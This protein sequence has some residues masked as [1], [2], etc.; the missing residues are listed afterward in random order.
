M[1]RWFLRIGAALLLFAFIFFGENLLLNRMMHARE[2]SSEEGWV[3]V[4]LTE[5]KGNPSEVIDDQFLCLVAGV[6][7]NSGEEN[8]GA[9]TRSDTLMLVKADFK[10][11]KLQL[12]SLPRDTRVSVNGEKTKLNH[13]HSYGGIELTMQ[14]V[15]NWLGIDLDY[16]VEVS[17][18]AVKHIVDTLGGVEYEIPDDGIQYDIAYT[19][20][21]WETLKPGLQKLNGEQALG[22]L[23]FRSGYALGDIGR[24]HAQQKF[25]QSFVKQTLSEASIQHIPGILQTVFSD[26]KTNIPWTTMLGMLD[27]VS[28]MKNGSLETYTIP[29]DGQY[30]SGISYYLP[31]PEETQKLVQQL[32]GDYMLQ[33]QTIKSSAGTE[34]QQ[35]KDGQSDAETLRRNQGQ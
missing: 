23:R 34:N 30:I 26:V 16:Y 6:D 17:F 20:G 7:I 29:G 13:A 11:G 1:K 10:T 8:T 25:L 31:D 35:E 14:T 33:K 2:Q 21:T 19:D 12:L 22:Y 18:D 27:K 24:V 32:F 9:E 4:E 28:I 15:R 3:N 5:H